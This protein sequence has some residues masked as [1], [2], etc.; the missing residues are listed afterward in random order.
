M[1]TKLVTITR[2]DVDIS[3][4]GISAMEWFIKAELCSS[5]SDFRR[6]VDQGAIKVN[7]TKITDPFARLVQDTANNTLI[8]VEKVE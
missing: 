6:M 2:D 4:I 3:E 5:K 8:I 7:D 1:K